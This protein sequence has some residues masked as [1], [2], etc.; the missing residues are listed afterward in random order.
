[1]TNPLL[2]ALLRPATVALVGAS[3]NVARLTSRP[4]RFLAQHGF[5]GRVVPVN[6]GRDTVLGVPA[7]KSVRD[8]EG[9]IDHAYILL[10]AELGMAAL[11]DCAAKGVK[12]VS[13]LADGFAEAGPEGRAR[14]DRIT[15]VA[16]EAGILLIGPN[17]TG[18]VNVGS[19]FSCTSNAAFA[20]ETLLPGRTAVLSQS[21][22]MIGMLG[23]RGAARGVGFSSMISVGN[24]AGAN[25]GTLGQLLLDDPETDAFAL[26]L[27]T[28]RDTAALSTFARAAHARGKPIVAYMIG[29]SAEGQALA[30]SHTG[31]LTGSTEAV[32]ALLDSLGIAQVGNLDALIDAPGAMARAQIRPERPR[33]VTVLSTTGG[34]GATVLDQISARGIAIAGCS[35]AARSV[36]EPQGIPLGHGKLVDV[37]MAG[38]NYASMRAVVETLMTDPDTGMLVVAV[39]S[40]AQFNPELAV[41]P[42]LDALAAAPEGAA[43]VVVVPL[44]HAPES[45]ALLS[46]GGVAA[47][48]SVESAAEGVASMM[49]ARPPAP[50]VTEVLPSSVTGLL[51]QA[52]SGVLDEVTSAQLYAA[53]GVNGPR[54]VVLEPDAAGPGDLPFAYPV[55]AKLVSPDL[56]HKTEAGAIAV[57][58]ADAAAVS[59]AIA[60]MKASAE[61]HAPGYCLKGIL[62][63]EMCV[64]LGE[65]LIGVTRDPLVGPVVTLAA[66]GV[67]TEIYRDSSVRPAPVSLDIAREMVGDINGFAPL[68]GYRGLPPGDL[69]ALAQAVARVSLLAINDRV[70]EAEI[71]PVLIRAEGQGTVLLD[72]LIKIG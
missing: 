71:N 62:I 20:A 21:G 57:S 30:V 28:V 2:E 24:E 12:V 39:G 54:A 9:P 7:V 66:G 61:G 3:D 60:R 29:Q 5:K 11:D 70:Q 33:S 47:F 19:G 69:E 13:M 45:L 64:G 53:L 56:P 43:P 35:D 46:A 16:Q 51:A 26:F 68:R 49:R 23:S 34:G 63:Q 10:D 32:G 58:L 55:V 18:V 50:P 15:A 22:S 8:I 44:P 67:M 25:V 42:I 17:S 6:P 72:A 14:Q 65:A 52:A 1:M 40:S 48:G 27:E 36:L 38:T 41:K 37:T 59:A 4:Q 31:A